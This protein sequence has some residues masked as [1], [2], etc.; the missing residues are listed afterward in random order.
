MTYFI[1]LAY[2]LKETG[3][4]ANESSTTSAK[5]KAGL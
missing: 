1:V 4:D 3:P 2:G 5:L